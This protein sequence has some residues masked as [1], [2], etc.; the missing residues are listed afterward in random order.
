MEFFG[1]ECTGKSE[2]L[3]NILAGCLLPLHQKQCV[4]F[5]DTDCHFQIIRLVQILEYRLFAK[6]DCCV[7]KREEVIRECLSR[8]YYLRCHSS[9]QL[10]ATVESLKTLLARKP[11][12]CCLMIDSISAFYWQDKLTL[13]ES[14]SDQ[15]QHQRRVVDTLK[16]LIA[17]YNLAVFATRG[18]F[19]GGSGRHRDDP[20]HSFLSQQWQKLVRHRYLFSKEVTHV[21]PSMALE[22]GQRECES[23]ARETCLWSNGE[24]WIYKAW[25]ISSRGPQTARSFCIDET[26]V[27]FL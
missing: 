3:L 10:V 5:I 26:G 21:D 20:T 18:M 4:I 24:D 1:D 25:L 6:D 22:D 9:I 13:G 17:N 27:K 8:F 12:I 15:E 11:E 2:M 23:L 14:F 16:D 7:E 19:V